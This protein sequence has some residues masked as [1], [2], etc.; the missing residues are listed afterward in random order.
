VVLIWG[1]FVVYQQRPVAV[2]FWET[3]FYTVRA[4]DFSDQDIELDILDGLGDDYPVYVYVPQPQTVEDKKLLIK[5]MEQDKLP[6]FQQIDRFQKIDGYYEEIFKHSI[7]ID[8]VIEY[9]QEMGQQLLGILEKNNS[10]INDN[11]YI[12]LV[13]T[14]RNIILVF[15][16]NSRMLGYLMAPYKAL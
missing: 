7:D 10:R 5:T 3:G 12:K 6:P 9:N 8:E 16:K 11:Y 4:V 1:I 2:V 15:D 13:S 14:Y